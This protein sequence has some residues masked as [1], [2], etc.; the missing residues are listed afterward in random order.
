VLDS[1]S[2]DAFEAL[3]RLAARDLPGA[4]LAATRSTTPLWL[5]IDRAVETSRQ[6][7]H[8]HPSSTPE[9]VTQAR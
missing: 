8:E 7:T 5:D 2:D 1:E 4:D 9:P 6:S 3:T